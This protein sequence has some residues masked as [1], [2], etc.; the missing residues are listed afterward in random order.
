[1]RAF[2]Q[3]IGKVKPEE[4]WIAVK[5]WLVRSRGVEATDELYIAIVWASP[6]CR[7]FSGLD[8]MQ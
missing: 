7:T 2:K 3:D 1:M 6:D 5:E 8:S 4:P